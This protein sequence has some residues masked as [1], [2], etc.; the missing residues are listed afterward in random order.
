MAQNKVK[1]DINSHHENHRSRL[2]ERYTQNGIDSFTECEIL[3]MLLFYAVPRKDTKPLAHHLLGE[4]G[5]LT[6]VLNASDDELQNAGAP[7]AFVFLRGFFDDLV[8]YLKKQK[9]RGIAFNDYDEAGGYMCTVLENSTYESIHA[10]LLDIKMQYI[11]E[12]SIGDGVRDAANLDISRLIKRC[13]ATGAAN[14]ILAH[15]HPAGSLMASTEDYLATSSIKNVLESINVNLTEHYVVSG[16]QYF[17]IL[18]SNS[19]YDN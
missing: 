8:G 9:N 5:S 18:K 12:M 16:K 14:V 13:V 1:I 19:F 7:K 11:S 6:G 2:R 4:F 17:G 3:E 10:V 15:N